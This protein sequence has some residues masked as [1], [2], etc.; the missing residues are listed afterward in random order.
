[1]IYPFHELTLIEILP[2]KVI[3]DKSNGKTYN[4]SDNCCCENQHNLLI[5]TFA[6]FSLLTDFIQFLTFAECND[7][8]ICLDVVFFL[9]SLIVYLS[10]CYQN[11]INITVFIVSKYL[12]IYNIIIHLLSNS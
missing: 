1:M 2:Q 5:W 10:F 9:D 7:L 3:H 12:D 11:A 4:H 6:N 8:L